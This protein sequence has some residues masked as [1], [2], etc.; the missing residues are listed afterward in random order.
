MRECDL[1]V[2]AQDATHR[3]AHPGEFGVLEH[4]LSEQGVRGEQGSTERELCVV[5][6]GVCPIGLGDPLD[7]D[8]RGDVATGVATH[9]VRDDEQVLAGVSAVLVIAAD[10]AHVRNCR[11]LPRGGHSVTAAVQ[12]SSYRF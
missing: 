7:G 5:R 12:S 9:T 8:S 3:R 6:G 4:G 10:F 11:T 2:D 1:V